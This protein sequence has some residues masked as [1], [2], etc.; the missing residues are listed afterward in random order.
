VLAAHWKNSGFEPDG[1]LV[2]PGYRPLPFDD[3]LRATSYGPRECCTTEHPMLSRANTTHLL[4]SFT[5]PDVY[6]EPDLDET[7]FHAARAYV[8]AH[9]C[10]HDG[11]QVGWLGR[12]V[13]R[14]EDGS[15]TLDNHKLMLG[16]WSGHTLTGDSDLQGHG[17]GTAIATYI[18]TEMRAIM[19]ELSRVTT[20]SV[21]VSDDATLR[22]GG[23]QNARR[24]FGWD[25]DRQEWDEQGA[26]HRVSPRRQ[27]QSVWADGGRDRVLGL[28]KDGHISEAE[29]SQVETLMTAKSGKVPT[30]RQLSELGADTPFVRGGRTTHLG[31]ELLLGAEWHGSKPL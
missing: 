9:I 18:E 6:L 23:Y 25:P 24:G 22:V 28:L 4:N 15:W 11:A 17:V 12:D 1:Q 8:S 31:K 27:V 20:F 16:T 29:F 7:F 26:P 30:P 2:A 10:T 3:S 21:S 14:N 19:P 13:S 5:H